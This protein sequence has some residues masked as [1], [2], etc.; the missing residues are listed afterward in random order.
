[1]GR[2]L[3][4]KTSTSLIPTP[5]TAAQPN[6]DQFQGGFG[7]AGQGAGQG[8]GEAGFG[9]PQPAAPQ[10]APQAQGQD[11]AQPGPAAQPADDGWQWN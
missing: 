3:S 9:G 2:F 11:G 1:M 6:P 7:Q 5:P 10:A 4:F 8:G